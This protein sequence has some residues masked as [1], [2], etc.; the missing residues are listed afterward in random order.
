M[1]KSTLQLLENNRKTHQA[2][3]QNDD[4][5][6]AIPMPFDTS[7]YLYGVMKLHLYRQLLH[8]DADQGDFAVTRD[9]QD[10]YATNRV[11]TL[12]SKSSHHHHQRDAPL[13]QVL[14]WTSDYMQ[15]AR[16]TIQPERPLSHKATEWMLRQLP[17]LTGQDPLPYADWQAQWRQDPLTGT[18][19]D[20]VLDQLSKH[21]Q[22]LLP[23]PME[24][25]YQLWLPTWGVV[26]QAWQTARQK[27]VAH[28]QRSSYKE[29]SMRSMQQPYSPIS[30][31]LLLD[32]MQEIG[33]V[34]IVDRPA[35]KFVRLPTQDE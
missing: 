34:E 16:N 26:V 24:Q 35:D 13:L 22:L 8:P 20:A 15:A 19:L 11:R 18:S 4:T 1:T 33:Q 25:S 6:L 3:Q 7:R 32:W 5:R 17:H 10:L 27:A 2:L 31:R 9:L 21:Q 29:R 14:V 30:T 23:F 12:S 28:I